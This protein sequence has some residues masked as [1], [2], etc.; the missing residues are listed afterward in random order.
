VIVRFIEKIEERYI[1][2]SVLLD[3]REM[4]SARFEESR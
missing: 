3:L 4:D 2:I 1:Y